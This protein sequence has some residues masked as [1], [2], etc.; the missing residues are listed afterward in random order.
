MIGIDT[1]AKTQYTVLLNCHCATG[2]VDKLL[3]ATERVNLE[4]V[5]QFGRE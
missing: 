2:K 4:L 3:Q 5:R 1:V